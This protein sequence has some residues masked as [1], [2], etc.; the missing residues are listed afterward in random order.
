MQALYSFNYKIPS[1]VCDVVHLHWKGE[2]LFYSNGAFRRRDT[3]CYGWW[4]IG[5]KGELKLKW[6]MWPME[7]LLLEG[8]R[9]IGSETEIFQRSDMP[10]LAR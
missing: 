3:S 9:F 7:Q 5:S 2:M 4:S 6:Q 8:E 1:A 10:S